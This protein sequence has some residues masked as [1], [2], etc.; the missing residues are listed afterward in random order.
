M[1]S[2]LALKALR[3]ISPCPFGNKLPKFSNPI[4]KR[5][6]GLDPWMQVMKR[7]ASVWVDAVE[8][9]AYANASDDVWGTG[10]VDMGGGTTVAGAGQG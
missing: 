3:S 9:G 4:S 2:T 5:H 10:G 1:Q 6:P 7:A 8:M